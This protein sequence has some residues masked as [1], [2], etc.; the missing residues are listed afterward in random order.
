MKDFPKCNRFSEKLYWLSL[1]PTMCAFVC[2][3]SVLLFL[4]LSVQEYVHHTNNAK[5]KVG[6]RALIF[7]ICFLMFCFRCSMFNVFLCFLQNFET[8]LIVTN[9]IVL[10]FCVP[11]INE[12]LL[13]YHSA[14]RHS[15]KYSTSYA[16]FPKFYCK[17]VDVFFLVFFFHF[18]LNWN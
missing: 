11:E 10:P 6:C 13:A 17:C 15:H 4:L 18:F 2:V 7:S 14:P 3:F 1:I 9:S 16:W 8:Q 12:I 5:Q